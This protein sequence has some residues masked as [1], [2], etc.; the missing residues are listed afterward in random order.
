MMRRM[1]PL[2]FPA[3]DPVL[4]PIAGPIS[5]RYYGLMYIVGFVAAQMI[6]SRLA[7]AR[8][9]PLDPQKVT[10]FIFY[11]VLGTILGGRLGYVVFYQPGLFDP[12]KIVLIWEGG[13]AFHGGLIGVTAAVW[14]FARKHGIKFG[15]MGDAAALAVTPGIFA[16]RM[17]NFINGELYG[18]ITAST[19]AFAMRFPTDELAQHSMGIRAVRDLGGSKRAEELMIQYA[20]GKVDFDAVVEHLPPAS[21]GSGVLEQLRDIRWEDVQES[22]PFRHPSQVYEGIGEGLVLGLILW[23]TYLLTRRRPLPSW[24]YAGLFLLGYGVIRFLLENVRQPDAQ[25]KNP[26]E[27]DDLGT[28]LMGLT[29][30]QVLCA[31]MI[32]IGGCLVARG[33]VLRR[34]GIDDDG[35]AGGDGGAAAVDP[36]APAAAE[37]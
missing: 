5:V 28:V 12:T 33:I 17:A 27:G 26:E 18:R 23:A 36:E 31:A 19:T 30:G 21:R 9:L 35:T 7:R 13:L 29:M 24:S 34:A 32:L 2:E 3:W 16:V 25:L 14:L 1:G 20:Y 10:D 6:L 4:I 8:F 37:G 11:A 22:V 15:R